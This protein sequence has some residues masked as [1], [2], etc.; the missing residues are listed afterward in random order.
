MPLVEI[1]IYKGEKP[2][3]NR[4]KKQLLIFLNSILIE[5]FMDLIIKADKGQVNG[6]LEV[7][8]QFGAGFP[9]SAS[10]CSSSDE[11]IFVVQNDEFGNFSIVPINPGTA[12][13]TYSASGIT[14]S[15]SIT[16][17]PVTL[18]ATSI[19]FVID[20]GQPD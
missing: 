7:K 20:Q 2:R 1:N 14:G 18:V 6:H 11:S 8:D 17:T 4:H 19:D 12:T 3:K 13:F 5:K 15:G 16:V 9:V 10:L